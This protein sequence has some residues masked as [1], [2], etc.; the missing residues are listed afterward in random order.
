MT[1]Y[2]R[3]SHRLIQRAGLVVLGLILCAG[4][5]NLA[6]L[7]VHAQDGP[8]IIK[9]I[10]VGQTVTGTLD[11]QTFMQ[12]YRL[13]ASTGDTINL[14]VTTTIEALA[15][16]VLLTDPAGTVI[17]QDI[18][19][20]TA[21]TASI[22]DTTLPSSGT[23][24][25][26]VVRGTGPDGDASG[27][28]TLQLGGIQ[29]V[30]GQTVNLENGGISFELVWNA[31]VNLDLEVRDPVGGTVQWRN[32]GSPSGGVL[33]A[34]VNA[35]CDAAIATS[36]TE[37]IGWPVGTVPAGS[38]EVIVYYNDICEV[39]G[40]QSFTLNSDVNNETPQVINGTINPGQ[41]YLARL[42][43]NADGTW[44]LVNGGVNA[45]LNVSVFRREIASAQTVAVGSTVSGTIT[46][47]VPA[48]AYLF[49]ATAGTTVNIAMNAQSGSLDPYLV[50]LGPDGL[51]L[52]D[53]DDAVDTTDSAI[54]RSLATDGQYTIIAT[55]YALSIGGTEGEFT[56]TLAAGTAVT[57]IPSG[58]ATTTD[59]G[60]TDTTGTTT[61]G[62]ILPQGAIQVKLE[63]T[64]NADLQLLVR[65]PR[66]DSVYDDIPT[67]AS[68]GVLE[69]DG[70]VNC[71]ETSTAPVSYI[72]WPNGRLQAGTYEIEV[73]FQSQCEDTTPVNFGLSVVV[74]GQ[75]VINTSQPSSQ[76]TRYMITFT[77]QPDGTV[78]AGAGGFFDMAEASSLQYQT[79]L[80]SATPIIYN[81][82]V[83]GSIT[84]QRRFVIYSFEGQ[85]GEAVTVGMQASGGTLDPALYLISPEGIQV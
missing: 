82:T 5:L 22:G 49:D 44:S 53:N 13:T 35:N 52:A 70:N 34:D 72:Y 17:A 25:I 3:I 65:D 2:L 4:L 68:G 27:S 64:T 14:D 83:S 50:L 46:N 21:T 8:T 7:P 79:M 76:G 20:A 45:G 32:P 71:L 56:L 15:P 51:P 54:S 60:T 1:A 10:T 41:A 11:S 73:W 12:M 39:G 80:A 63:W 43:I 16:V 36:P 69:A 59:T 33:D 40:S 37:I 19:Q 24:H 74:E 23:Y 61:T 29:Q 42:L 85:Q 77:V 57:G 38:Y 62:V 26:I 47:S 84:D 75:T 58:D 9:P 78:V 28:F 66:G 67:I 55:R 30:G 48:Q 18:D 31:A 81:Q 6:P